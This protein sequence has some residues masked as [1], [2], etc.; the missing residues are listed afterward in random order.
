MPSAL[1]LSFLS[2][3]AQYI[4]FVKDVEKSR[5]RNFHDSLH[6]L[7]IHKFDFFPFLSHLI[8]AGCDIGVQISVRPYVRS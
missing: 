1:L 7:S 5:I 2:Y 4:Y 3:Y 6:E 8:I